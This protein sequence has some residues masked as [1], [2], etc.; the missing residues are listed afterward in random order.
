MGFHSIPAGLVPHES[1]HVAGGSDDIDSA[2]A[3][4]AMADLGSTKIWQGNVG[5]RPVEVNMPAAGA[6]L[7]VAETEVFSGTTP[8]PIAWT[9]LDLKAVVGENHALVLLKFHNP[10][11]TGRTIAVRPNG[12]TDESFYAD[13]GAGCA[14]GLV[15]NVA[16]YA[17]FWIATDATGKVEWC[18][19]RAAEDNVTIDVVAFL[20]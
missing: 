10:S 12:D 18:Y 11:G 16:D 9:D 15:D 20:K 17:Y 4:A 2:L 5:N 3:I 6:V 1:T 14:S 19:D 13:E 7:V 8:D